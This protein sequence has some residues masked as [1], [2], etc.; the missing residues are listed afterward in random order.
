MYFDVYYLVLV[1]PTLILSLWAQILVKSTFAKYSRIPS[2]RHITGQETAA[3]LMRAN[4]IAHVA[5]EPV[6][7][8]LTDHYDPGARVLRLSQPVYRQSSIAAVG[9]A[10]H[11]TGHA[12]QHALSYGPLILRSTLVPVANVGSSLGPWL[13]VAGIFFSFPLLLNLGIFLF[14][15]AV[16][17][18]VITLPVEFNA[19]ARAISLLRANR[20]LS[21][22]ELRGVK[23][24]LTAA[25]LTYVAS[26]LTALMSFLRL[27]LIARG[28]RR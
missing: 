22:E 2:S 11:E 20:I 12:I 28:R 24:V 13:A 10:A 23:K 21:E 14:G 6:G 4:H 17:F 8:S 1:V 15:G 9:I 7:G 5:I 3:V 19:S 18:Y 16:L 25:A 26:A 27:I